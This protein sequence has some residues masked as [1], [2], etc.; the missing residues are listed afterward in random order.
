MRIHLFEIEDQAW[1]P[2]IFRN[3]LTDFLRH[4]ETATNIYNETIPIIKKGLRFA[5]SNQIIDL[6][7]G[8]SGPWLTLKQ[9]INRTNVLL[10][11]LYPNEQTIKLTDTLKIPKVRYHCKPV[12]A[13]AVDKNLRGLKTLFGSF[14][15][16]RPEQAKKILIDAV[17]NNDPIAVFEFTERKFVNLFIQPFGVLIS[18]A[19]ITPFIKPFKISRLIFTYLIP[20][21]P[22]MTIWD[23]Y[24]SNLRTYSPK[25]L[26]CMTSAL[27]SYQWE[28]GIIK[29]KQPLINITY[30][31]GHPKKKLT[32][33]LKGRESSTNS[34]A[35][36][37]EFI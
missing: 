30:L 13:L 14:H 28:I 7:S 26:L 15:H 6:C 22:L 8:G 27:D 3:F 16:F 36:D 32:G 20:I 25:E 1:C 24:I 19:L 23:G 4:F 34:L 17:G 12:D 2:K 9:E 10:T 35:I 31:L 29:T 18:M 33:D 37:R 11:D 5:S 21:V